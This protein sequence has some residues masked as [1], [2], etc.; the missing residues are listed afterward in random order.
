M[1]NKSK[2]S[3]MLMEIMRFHAAH[4]SQNDGAALRLSLK[5]LQA[6][7]GKDHRTTVVVNAALKCLDE[8][9][10][11]QIELQELRSKL[12]FSAHE[13]E[14]C[15]DLVER[16]QLM[17]DVLVNT[18]LLSCIDQ[19]ANRVSEGIKEYLLQAITY[20]MVQSTD[21]DENGLPDD[22]IIAPQLKSL[23][24][25][26]S[27]AQEKLAANIYTGQQI[28]PASAN[29][30]AGITSDNYEFLVCSK[31]LAAVFAFAE[32]LLNR[33][34]SLGEVAVNS[35]PMFGN[36]SADNAKTQK[37]WLLA[38]GLTAATVADAANSMTKDALLSCG[39]NA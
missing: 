7:K 15:K 8:H 33:A 11:L 6:R 28:F 23:S 19:A 20:T 31:S 35:L 13:T 27:A 9:T 18:K 29:Q 12:F 26:V 5:T 14:N 36:L 10:W 4:Q 32:K 30:D 34:T 17:L 21:A 37:Q 25:V 38:Y 16:E 1:Q 39:V 2:I 24:E 22:S 3:E